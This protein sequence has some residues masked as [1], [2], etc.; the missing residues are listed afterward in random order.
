MKEY[1]GKVKTKHTAT[2]NYDSTSLR[3]F[4]KAESND[5]GIARKISAGLTE[6][7]DHG[8]RAVYEVHKRRFK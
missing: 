1:H 7:V 6:S 8:N 5:Q 3:G 2:T 4:G